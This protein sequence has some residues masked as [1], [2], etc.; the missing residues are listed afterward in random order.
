MAAVETRR[1]LTR[2]CAVITDF[3]PG[4]GD[5]LQLHGEASHY[6]VEVNGDETLLY[7]VADSD[8]SDP[9]YSSPSSSTS[10]VWI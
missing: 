1:F 2:I 9:R 6:E 3:N 5:V 7:H 4:E 8:L 10:A